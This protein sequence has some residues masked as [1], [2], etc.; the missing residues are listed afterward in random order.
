MTADPTDAVVRRPKRGRPRRADA[1]GAILTATLE[2]L[3]EVGVAGLSMDLLAQ[4]AGVGKATIYRRW[5]S[6]EALILDA[7]RTMTT[8]LPVP[9]EGSLRADLHA[10]LDTVIEHVK[11]GRGSDVLPHLIEASCYDEQLRASLD[12]Y[13][14]ER[15]STTRLLLRRGI[16]RGE[17][18]AD[19][20]VDLLTDVIMAPLFYRLL[21]TGAPLDQDFTHR[22]VDFALR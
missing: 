9:D 18:A 6:K 19:A 4:R 15:Q 22:L 16:E 3:G 7:L 17:L 21:L 10:Y 13:L 11:P 12:D 5:E 20:D 8:P 14:R 2:L 1:D